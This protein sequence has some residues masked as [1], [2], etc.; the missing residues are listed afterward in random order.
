MAPILHLV[1]YDVS[2]VEADDGRDGRIIYQQHFAIADH[3]DLCTIAPGP[4][5]DLSGMFIGFSALAPHFQKSGTG[6]AA[7]RFLCT[8][9]SANATLQCLE[10]VWIGASLIFDVNPAADTTLAGQAFREVTPQ[11]LAHFLRSHMRALEAALR[12][13]CGSPLLWGGFPLI[14]KPKRKELAKAGVDVAK[15]FDA[16]HDPRY[17]PPSREF[18]TRI[19]EDY[20]CHIA[21]MV[22]SVHTCIKRGSDACSLFFGFPTIRSS[23]KI[24]LGTGGR[25][26]ISHVDLPVVLLIDGMLAIGATTDAVARS[27]CLV[28]YLYPELIRDQTKH[29]SNNSSTSSSAYYFSAA[30]GIASSSQGGAEAG[31]GEASSVQKDAGTLYLE[32]RVAAPEVWKCVSERVVHDGLEHLALGLLPINYTDSMERELRSALQ[33]LVAKSCSLT[34][35]SSIVALRNASRFRFSEPSLQILWSAPGY[36]SGSSTLFP[37]S[38]G[39]SSSSSNG[40]GGSGGVGNGSSAG[41]GKSDHS[42]GHHSNAGASSG[43]AGGSISQEQ[44]LATPYSVRRL[45]SSSTRDSNSAS[46]AATVASTTSPST[47][48]ERSP[49]AGAK[50]PAG[51]GGGSSSSASSSSASALA[52]GSGAGAAVLSQN[53]RAALLP[54]IRACCHLTCR[55]ATFTEKAHDTASF[56]PELLKQPNMA[57][58]SSFAAG[59]TSSSSPPA[60]SVETKSAP[61][62]ASVAPA[63]E[64]RCGAL[65]ENAPENSWFSVDDL[66]YKVDDYSW[67]TVKVVGGR[68]VCVMVVASQPGSGSSEQLS[69]E[70]LIGHSNAV[71]LLTFDDVFTTTLDA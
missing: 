67:A 20:G 11:C 29:R 5:R 64:R 48:V 63:L 53:E 71:S 34:V 1:V 24:A 2:R 27:L 60:T 9:R 35:A 4:C 15:M 3:P 52:L 50:F 25:A 41:A 66:T 58:S 26:V 33:Q 70:E 55:M 30:T 45:G 14:P 51:G 39:S 7:V 59:A 12:A 37:S 68:A 16:V 62:T 32:S 49:R 31:G 18:V 13:T 56:L 36:G 22:G 42:A 69:V 61:A 23:V 28:N 19:C 65:P 38:S 40:G 17:L 47:N 8:E 54:L 46:A 44:L 57:A 6:D 43:A 21:R 10:E